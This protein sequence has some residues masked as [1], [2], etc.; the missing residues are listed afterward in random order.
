MRQSY[1]ALRPLSARRAATQ[2]AQAVRADS[3]GTSADVR[4]AFPRDSSSAAVRRNSRAEASARRLS[5][6][7]LV[8]TPRSGLHHA[9][10]G[11]H[12]GPRRPLRLASVKSEKPD[13]DARAQ[14]SQPA[15]RLAFGP[16]DLQLT[17]P[18]HRGHR[19]ARCWRELSH[20]VSF[21]KNGH[22]EHRRYLASCASR[23]GSRAR[24]SHHP[25]HPRGDAGRGRRVP[26]TIPRRRAPARSRA[27]LP[28]K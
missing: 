23:P 14:V 25:R 5:R 3:A 7:R 16:G 19:R 10:R 4:R 11:R 21:T 2:S 13:H 18:Q 22:Y 8:G 26:G 17:D 15:E 12:S 28:P 1:S 6:Q 27:R 9:I 24:R 20:W